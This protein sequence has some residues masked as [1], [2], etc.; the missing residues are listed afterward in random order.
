MW[1][2]IGYWITLTSIAII[3]FLIGLVRRDWPIFKL[4]YEIDIVSLIIGIL[5][6]SLTLWI[7]YWVSNV[8]EKTRDLN[9]N[10][11]ELTLSKIS[12]LIKN[13]DALISSLTPGM[14]P[15]T[16]VNSSIKYSFML[17]NSILD[18]VTKSRTIETET[19]YHVDLHSNLRE[20]KILMTAYPAV[21]AIA[22]GQVEPVQII[23]DVYNYTPNRV[24][25]IEQKLNIIKEVITSY[26]LFIIQS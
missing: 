22:I 9:R 13:I 7:A 11:R 12:D 23:N 16:I 24:I 21:P 26:S 17:N 14:I 25:E 1:K 3:A 5:T 19:S 18:L 4:K 15:N 8:I 10:E 6:L 2:K 20:L